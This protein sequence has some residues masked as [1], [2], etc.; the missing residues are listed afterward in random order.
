MR[1]NAFDRS[2][3]KGYTLS[4]Y[5]MRMRYLNGQSDGDSDGNA[6]CNEGLWMLVGD[7]RRVNVLDSSMQ[8]IVW[9]GTVQSGDVL[10]VANGAR[11]QVPVFMSQ[12]GTDSVLFGWDMLS[13][14]MPFILSEK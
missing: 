1:N 3:I 5:A 14:D 4:G 9:E 13:C 8:N 11:I 7:K 12:T 10:I 2:G 6:S